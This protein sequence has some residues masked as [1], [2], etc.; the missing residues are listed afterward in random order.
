M[1]MRSFASLWMTIFKMN[2]MKHF[3]TIVVGLL[4]ACLPMQAQEK[5]LVTPDDSI[6]SLLNRLLPSVNPDVSAH[7]NLEF[8]TSAAGYFTEGTFDEAAFKINRVRLEILGSFSK[9]FNWHF[10][11][12]FNKYSNPHALDNLSSSIE[13]AYVNWKPTDKF[14]MTIGKQFVAMGGY[15]YYLNANKVREFSDFNEYVAAYQAGVAAAFNASPTQEW[16]LQVTN[17]R[18]GED[19]DMYVY[20]RPMGIA[21]AKVPVITTLNWNGLFADK[22]LQFRYAASWGQQAEGRNILYL[23][24]AN[25]YEKGPV[26]AYVDVMYS[27]QGLD[28]HCIISD[29]QG[30]LVEN[31]VTAQNTEYLSVIADIDYRF[32]PHWNAYIKGAYETAGVYKTNGLFEKGLYRTTWNLQGC[33]EFFPMK[34]SEL[35]IFGHLLY[36]GH[37]LTDRAR[38]LG[39]VAPDTQRISVGLVYTIPV[40]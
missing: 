39:A 7:M 34:G 13:F 2:E 3:I 22:T 29:M 24:A 31:P 11:Q 38:A 35:M 17:F 15:E 21:K 12:S 25:V 19:E 28:T 8:Y 6:Q 9:D 18:S 5:P 37:Q 30:P 26:I 14:N 23:T 36:K 16:V 10:R 27:R 20:G 33:V 1:Y 40:F 32:H 4:L